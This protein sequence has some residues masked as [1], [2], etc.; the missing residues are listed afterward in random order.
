MSLAEA[1]KLRM[2]ALMKAKNFSQYDFYKIG[3]IPKATAS[4]VLNKTRERVSVKTVYEMISAM[5]VS[6][7][8]FF[9]DPIFD[10]VTD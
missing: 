1:I 10:E 2:L 7:T 8:E 5:D 9:D 6:L 4:Q 3:G